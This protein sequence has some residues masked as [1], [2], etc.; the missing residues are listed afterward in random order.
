MRLAWLESSQENTEVVGKVV[1]ISTDVEV[2]IGG[3]D[4]AVEGKWLWDGQGGPQFWSGGET[5][6]SVGN[7]YVAWTDGAPNDGGVGEDCAVLIAASA[8]WGDRSCSIKYAYLC[9]EVGP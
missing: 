2:W 3:T 9:E 8:T 5:G 7:Q 4:A 1:V 6:K